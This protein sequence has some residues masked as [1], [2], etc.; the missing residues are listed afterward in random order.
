MHKMREKSAKSQEKMIDAFMRKGHVA[1]EN[2]KYCKLS[3]L[4]AIFCKAFQQVTSSNQPRSQG[5][6]HGLRV[7][8]PHHQAREKALGT[9]LVL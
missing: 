7:V 4:S 8:L 6:F 2:K 5:L 1:D 9:R 3:A